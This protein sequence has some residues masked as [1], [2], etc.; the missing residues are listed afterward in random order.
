[1]ID[2]EP[3]IM[4]MVGEWMYS[5]MMMAAM[6]Q[7]WKREDMWQRWLFFLSQSSACSLCI[8]WSFHIFCQFTNC[9][10][11]KPSFKKSGIL[12]KSFI[13]WRSPPYCFYEILI[14]N[15][16]RISEYIYIV[17]NK[18]YEIWLT[19]PPLFANFFNKKN[20]AFFVDGFLK[21]IFYQ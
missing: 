14:Q 12:W 4:M 13:K 7:W 20:P 6:K 15:F 19:P 2:T 10:K 11:G 16:D 8:I 1:M 17:L 3:M 21:L 5:T 18:R 9:S